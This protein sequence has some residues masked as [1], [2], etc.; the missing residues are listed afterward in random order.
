MG[1]YSEAIKEFAKKNGISNLINEKEKT[2][3]LICDL[4]TKQHY[5]VHYSMLQLGSQLGYRVERIHN[6]IKFKQAPF[7]FEYVNK[8]STM[9]AQS[10][11]AVLKNL[12][13]LLANSIYGKFV[14]TGLKRMKVKIATNKKEQDAI[15]TKYSTDLIDDMQLYDE[16]I[17]AAKLFNPV[18]RLSKPFFIGFAILDMSKYIIYDFYYNKLKKMFNNVTL[19]GQDTDSL[20]VKIRDENTVGKMLDTYKCFDFSE[21]DTSSYFYQKLVKYYNKKVAGPIFKDEHQGHR[22]T[23]FLRIKTQVVLHS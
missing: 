6:V 7:I 22:I 17:W 19:L 10:K 16:N 1:T 20:I 2:K 13:K 15:I 9:H 5:V 12:F 11:T 4:Y 21:L 8:L 18:K 14:E 3:K 23:E